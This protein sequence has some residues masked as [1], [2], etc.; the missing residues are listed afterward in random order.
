MA[1]VGR[2]TLPADRTFGAARDTSGAYQRAELHDGLVMR[3]GRATGARQQ[4]ARDAPDFAFAR[5]RPVVDVGDE[6]A[7]QYARDV[8]VDELR[9][10]LVRERR[11]GTRGIVADPGELAQQLRIRGQWLV[12]QC[13]LLCHLASEAMEVAGT[14]I[15]PESLPRL[16]HLPRMRARQLRECREAMEEP[17]VV[18]DDARDLGLLEHELRHEHAI[19]IAGLSPWKVAAAAPIPFSQPA[20]EGRLTCLV[21]ALALHDVG[22]SVTCRSTSPR[23]ARIPARPRDT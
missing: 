4:R 22:G 17:I 23:H 14:S 11:D 8:G 1:K 19:W 5:C 16:A 9:A 21:L 13:A 18:R 2:Q 20:T 15:V 7:A 3:P 10:P 12:R 6:G